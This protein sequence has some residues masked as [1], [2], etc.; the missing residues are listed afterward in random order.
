M[1]RYRLACTPPSRRRRWSGTPA[2][3]ASPETSRRCR[4]RPRRPPGS[5][6]SA[7]A[8]ATRTYSSG[9]PSRCRPRRPVPTT[10]PAGPSCCRCRPGPPPRCGTEHDIAFV[11]GPVDEVWPELDDAVLAD[12]ALRPVLERC[13]EL[14]RVYADWSLLEADGPLVAGVPAHAVPAV[15]LSIQLALAQALRG[16][17]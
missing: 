10:N 2:G 8:A 12:P 14:L 7:S 16:Y 9:R 1:A 6:R 5:A 11:V 13:D 15:Q 4:S 3:C 17:G